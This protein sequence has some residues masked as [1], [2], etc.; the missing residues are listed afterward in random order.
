MCFMTEQTHSWVY[1]HSHTS[2]YGNVDESML[3]LTVPVDL[4]ETKC[5]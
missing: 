4:H 2:Q 3:N 5:N 1:L